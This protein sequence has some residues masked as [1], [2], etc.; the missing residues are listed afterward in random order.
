MKWLAAAVA[1]VFAV[2]FVV[3]YGFLLACVLVA[4]RERLRERYLGWRMLRSG[5]P[6]RIV[7]TQPY[8]FVVDD[9]GNV[10]DSTGNSWVV[11]G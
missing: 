5:E 1:G 10:I 9:A 6:K 2:A 4:L 8:T 11:T 3:I 7:A